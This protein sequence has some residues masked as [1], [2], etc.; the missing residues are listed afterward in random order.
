MP[1][2]PDITVYV[3]ALRPRVEGQVLRALRAV[4]PFLLRSVEP[5][6]EQTAGGRVAEVRPLGKRAVPT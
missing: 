3:E 2:L 4:S 5:P 1:E 6:A